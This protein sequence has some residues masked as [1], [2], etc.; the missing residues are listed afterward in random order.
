[1]SNN[2]YRRNV[3]AQ[4]EQRMQFDGAFALAKVGPGKQRQAEIDSGR[5]ERVDG[6]LQSQAEVVF[7]VKRPRCLDQQLGKVGV[8]APVAHRV[9][10]RQRVARNATANAQVIELGL[11]RAQTSFD[12]A[13]ALAIS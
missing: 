10:V 6:L 1:M 9:G 3:A 13:Q 2:D 4:V 8:D 12:V 11:V 7:E 5:I